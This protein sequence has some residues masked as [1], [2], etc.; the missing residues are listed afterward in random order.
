MKE[1]FSSLF[2]LIKNNKTT[3][4]LVVLSV[5]VLF[6]LALNTT[7][8]AFTS[9]N[10]NN[11]ANVKVADLSFN[12]AINGTVRDIITAP[13][14]SDATQNIKL[15]SLNNFG[16][17]YEI[18]YK[19]CE[20]SACTS[21]IPLPSGLKVKYSDTTAA[22]VNG[23]LKANASKTITLVT[24][25]SLSTTYYIKIFINAGYENNT[26]ALTNQINE[27]TN[28]EDIKIVTT[29]D[30]TTTNT[31]PTNENYT[32]TT[33]CNDTGT[34]LT[35]TWNGSKWVGTVS[36]LNKSGVI[37]TA[38]FVFDDASFPKYT[39]NGSLHYT[40]E[41]SGNWHVK[42]TTG[43]TLTIEKAMTIDVFLVG[44]G[45]GGD[46][47]T[48][49]YRCYGGN[50]GRGG[51]IYTVYNRK[52]PAGTYAIEIGSGGSSGSAGSATNA[53]SLSSSSGTAGAAGGIGASIAGT[54]SGAITYSTA[55]SNGVYAFGTSAIDGVMY[56]AGGGGAACVNTKFVW[57]KNFGGESK[58]G[59]TTGGGHGAD[60]QADGS[61]A[62]NNT[63]SGGGG[64]GAD[65]SGN[66]GGGAH[67][68][69]GGYGGSG[70]IIIRNAR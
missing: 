57:T 63:G 26:L 27:S 41:G 21:F 25:N 17:K 15:T 64:G 32:V 28:D 55:G 51:N 70:V 69:S 30:G 4:Y 1:K 49:G 38:A 24:E 65:A 56:A 42:F 29:V 35:F 47:G 3:R 66:G 53:F 33:S 6:V 7:Y 11:L 22:P 36:G 68:Y 16:V 46:A 37:C 45:Y 20:T 48:G 23:I 31:P 39:Y 12:I 61:A 67:S 58:P 9:N 18:T 54:D 52:I 10:T 34:T 5:L 2:N 13:A 60:A 19:V 50:G 40:D 62:T 8:S 44:G 43:G 14:N 59:G